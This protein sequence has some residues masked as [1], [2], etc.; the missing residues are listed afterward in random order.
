[1]TQAT[2]HCPYCNAA[3]NVPD[4]SSAESRLVCERCGESVPLSGH[5]ISDGILTERPAAAFDQGERFAGSGRPSNRRLAVLILTV[6]ALMA[7]VGLMFALRTQPFRRARDLPGTAGAAVPP[8]P[9]VTFVAPAELPALGYLD[10]NIDVVSAINVARALREPGSAAFLFPA[11]GGA[12]LGIERLEKW[13]SL[14]PQDF[15]DVVAG[16]SLGGKELQF[17]LIAATSR[18]FNPR[19]VRTNIKEDATSELEVKCPNEQTL[20][21]GFPK[22]RELR[23]R[24]AEPPELP[25]A[26]VEL[27]RE[28]VDRS[29]SFW[30]VGR[31]DS[32]GQTLAPFL[33]S[34]LPAEVGKLLPKVRQFALWG[35][36]S[37]PMRLTAHFDCVDDASAAA[38]STALARW[39]PSGV[40]VR[41][42]QQGT[43]LTVQARG[44]PAQIQKMISDASAAQP[45]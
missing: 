11:G 34:V 45:K 15:N 31:S 37:D 20:I 44:S 39:Q 24:P 19:Q 35:Q 21:I 22:D 12:N 26:L 16:A 9:T 13:T 29:A 7:C 18:P 33:G 38:L 42:A 30:L 14:K 6:M 27:I 8:S 36:C 40:T 32:L 43:W 5:E 23:T 10:E 41:K 28:R 2:R 3:I 17:T 1:M 25:A 4:A